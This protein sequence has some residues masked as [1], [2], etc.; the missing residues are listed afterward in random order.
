M[1]TE[2]LLKKSA[3]T[4]SLMTMDTRLKKLAVM[5]IAIALLSNFV[6]ANVETAFSSSYAGEIDLFTQKEPYS[7]KGLNMPSDAFAPGEVV[8]LYALVQ[9]GGA[10]VQNFLVTFYVRSP[11]NSSFSLVAPTN[12]SGVAS[13]NFAI[14]QKCAPHESEVF[15]EWFTLASVRIGSQIFQDTLSFKVGYIVELISV[16]TI[17]ENLNNRSYFGIGGDVGF[18]ITLKNIAMIGKNASFAIVIKDDL[19]VL[20]SFLEIASFEV[21]PNEKLIF[22]YCKLEIPKSAFVGKAKVF[23][24]ALTAPSGEGGAPYCPSI[25]TEFFITLT[26]PLKLAFHD[27][28]IVKVALSATSVMAGKTVSISVTVRNEG[29]E[30]ESFNVS[31]Y[32][33][34]TLIGTTEVLA[35]EPYRTTTINFVLN[36]SAINPGNYIIKCLIPPITNEADLTDNILVDGTIEIGQ[37]PTVARYLVTF[38]QEGLASDA[39]GTV[40]VVNG[41]QLTFSYLPY[42]LWVDEGDKITYSYESIV[43]STMLKKQF[44]LQSV[45]GPSSPVTVNANM[46]ITGNY[47][48]QYMVTFE[49]TGVDSSAM[50]DI[51]TINGSSKSYYDLPYS[52][53]ADNGTTISYSYN[54][55]VSSTISGKRFNLTDVIGPSAPLIVTEPATII[56]NYKIQYFLSVRTDPTGIATIPGE[57]WY[58]ALQNVTLTAV[59]VSGYMFENWDV[60]GAFFAAGVKNVTVFMDRPRTATAHYSLHAGGGYVP[61][62]FYWLILLLLLLAI[63]LL[64]LWLYR[65]RERRKASLTFYRGWTAWY[66]C[67]NLRGNLK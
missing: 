28:A 8:I 32:Y 53:W 60:D 13:V 67:Y 12:G 21:Q 14:P 49:H 61:W 15:G 19:N 62:W 6:L 65:R 24:S 20:V 35:L 43:S 31:A 37:L 25:S 10:P 3:Y 22:L 7:G 58:D 40:V 29:T 48:A 30:P 26:E 11:D 64:V 42:S 33:N 34:N 27:A 17:D 51:V 54:S 66:Y 39:S 41:T 1:I 4:K 5:L 56:G 18:E 2:Y 63:A 38:S 47:I 23:V 9:Y 46:T 57:G 44:K 45:V 55:M 50:G 52:L 59:T 36:T 16:R